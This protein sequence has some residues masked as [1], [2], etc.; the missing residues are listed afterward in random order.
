MPRVLALGLDP[1]FADYSHMP[2]L[3]P[4]LVGAFIESQLQRVRDAGYEVDSCLVDTGETAE[5]TLLRCLESKSFDCVMIGAALRDPARLQLFETLIN[6][7]HGK[8]PTAK[9][10]FNTKPGDT[11]EAVRR[12]V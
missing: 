8:A 5:A 9:L 1:R 12:R 2:A 7:V 10:C 11:L 6:T 3:T 4:E